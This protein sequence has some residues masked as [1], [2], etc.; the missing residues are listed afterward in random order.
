MPQIDENHALQTQVSTLEEQ[1]AIMQQQF[2][3]ITIEH[4]YITHNTSQTFQQRDMSPLMP[5][6]I[7]PSLHLNLQQNTNFVLAQPPAS[8]F[9]KNKPQIGKRLYQAGRGRLGSQHLKQ[10]H[11]VQ[12]YAGTNQAYNP[13]GQP[14]G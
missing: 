2:N 11:P 1:L 5:L 14:Q 4:H 6:P 13:G 12:E 7:V 3:Y 9:N 8:F 10:G